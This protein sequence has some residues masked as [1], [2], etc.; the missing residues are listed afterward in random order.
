MFYQDFNSHIAYPDILSEKFKPH[1]RAIS[2]FA[3]VPLINHFDQMF[4]LKNYFLSDSDPSDLKKG[5]ATIASARLLL[6]A[7]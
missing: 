5:K 7:V 1:K 6:C 4:S 2:A 3:V